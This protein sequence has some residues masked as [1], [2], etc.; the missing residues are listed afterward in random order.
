MSLKIKQLLYILQ[1]KN[2]HPDSEAVAFKPA[3]GM[4]GP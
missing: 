4:P 2:G 3:L 1:S